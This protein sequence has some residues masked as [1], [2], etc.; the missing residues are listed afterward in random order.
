MYSTAFFL[1]F[2]EEEALKDLDEGI[3]STACGAEHS[4]VGSDAVTEDPVH[5]DRA[6]LVMRVGQ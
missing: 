3:L 1:C 4:Y 6:V 5:A 2:P